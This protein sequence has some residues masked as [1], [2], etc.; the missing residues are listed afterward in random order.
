MSDLVPLSVDFRNLVLAQ[1]CRELLLS[2]VDDHRAS[3][4]S[5]G[6]VGV[7]ELAALLVTPLVQECP[8]PLPE[9]VVE[10]HARWQHGW[11]TVMVGGPTD[12]EPEMSD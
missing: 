12:L 7:E 6:N 4:P 8:D 11:V 2:A 10:N 3:S 5:L 1:T 9:D